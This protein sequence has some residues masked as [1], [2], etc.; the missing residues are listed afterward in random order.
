MSLPSI[1]NAQ[2]V[3]SAMSTVVQAIGD[4]CITPSEGEIV[5]N[6]LAVKKDVLAACDFERRLEQVE[7]AISILKN[8]TVDAEAAEPDAGNPDRADR[9]R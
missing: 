4:G 7:Q 5:A 3:S 1:E 9:L 2:Q 8:A 6:V